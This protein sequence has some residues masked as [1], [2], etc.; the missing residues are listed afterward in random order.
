M[1]E[2]KHEG[3]ERTLQSNEQ[4][5]ESGSEALVEQEE[6]LLVESIGEQHTEW[7]RERE[8]QTHREGPV[9]L[10]SLLLTSGVPEGVRLSRLL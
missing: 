2:D 9:F 3:V 4:L 6:S 8:Y 7:T 5:R 10:P 1:K